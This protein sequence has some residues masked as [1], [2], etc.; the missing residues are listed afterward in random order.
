MGFGL[1]KELGGKKSQKWENGSKSEIFGPFSPFFGHFST[2]SGVHKRVFFFVF[3]R[4]FGIPRNENWN[5]G[6]FACSPRMKTGTRVRLHV[7]PE[8]KPERGH[9]RQNHPLLQNRPF[10]SRWQ[11]PG[12]AKIH[13]YFLPFSFPKSVCPKKLFRVILNLSG[14]FYF[15]RLFLETLRKHP[16]NKHKIDISKVIFTSQGCFCL[17]RS[18][19]KNNPKRFLGG[20]K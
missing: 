10:V 4:T 18:K 7:P 9:I 1:T 13:F 17:A 11:F 6:T 12:E 19:V 5:Q 14:Y 8:Q 20:S 2:I 15:A 16:L 3:W